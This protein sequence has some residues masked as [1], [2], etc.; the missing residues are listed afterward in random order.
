MNACL[1]IARICLIGLLGWGGVSAAAGPVDLVQVQAAKPPAVSQLVTTLKIADVIEVMRQEGLRYGES[2]EQELFAGNGGTGWAAV[3]A[4]IYDAPTMR[5]RFDEA[6]AAAL[7]GQE[8]DLAAMDGFFATELGQRILTLEVEARRSLMDEA[9]EDA[10][11]AQVDDML[12]ET[13]PRIV[14]LQEFSDANDLIELNVAGAMNANLAFSQ[15]MAEVGGMDGGMS[16]EDMLAEVWAQEPDIREETEDWVLPYLAMAYASLSDDELADY[17]AF[18]KTGGGRAL[19]HA[20]FS[21]FD[22]LFAQISRDLGRAAA[23]Q[24]IGQDI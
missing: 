9:V 1:N 22:K 5:A 4:L 24:M 23:N 15:G 7:T 8:A 13:A 6:F 12:A 18:S 20:L 10:A 11:R 2:M 19:N 16:E 3:V 14:A 17:I 21:A